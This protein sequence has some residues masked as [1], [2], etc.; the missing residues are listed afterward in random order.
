[1]HQNGKGGDEAELEG[2][3]EAGGDGKPVD[4]VVDT[5]GCQVEVAKDL[6]LSH[7]HLV[8]V[9][10][11]ILVRELKY[12]F[13]DK[14]GEDA[15]EDPKPHYQQSCVTSTMV[16]ECGQRLREEVE[17]DVSQKTAHSKAQKKTKF[18]RTLAKTFISKSSYFYLSCGDGCLGGYKEQGSKAS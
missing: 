8:V 12:L 14:K 17:K 16:A 4:E 9:L 7:L 3:E 11:L 10:L 5:V 18:A 15:S 2:G 6:F 13:E 1:M